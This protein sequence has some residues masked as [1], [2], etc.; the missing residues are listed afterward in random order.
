MEQLKI[1]SKCK[2]EKP[3]S[4]FYKRKDRKIGIESRC[5]LCCK[6]KFKKFLENNK[7]YFKE[8][9]AKFPEK[10]KEYRKKDRLKNIDKRRE[11]EKQYNTINKDKRLENKRNRIKN[12]PLFKLSS[13]MRTALWRC[14]KNKTSR[15]ENIVGCTFEYLKIYIESKFEPWMTWDNYGV[16]NGEF[17]YGW[18]IDHIIPLSSSNTEEELIKLNHYSNLQPL[19][20]KINREIKKDN[21]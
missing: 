10:Y 16:Y 15:T 20:S 12:D 19:C 9:K 1:C 8:H 14:I 18:D 3:Y 6:I 21:Y 5:K 11:Y 2:I 17:N 7:E 13:N 4:E